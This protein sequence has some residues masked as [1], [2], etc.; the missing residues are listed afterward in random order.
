[1]T[2]AEGRR[3]WRRLR[4]WGDRIDNRAFLMDWEPVGIDLADEPIRDEIRRKAYRL[5]RWLRPPVVVGSADFTDL[6][7]AASMLR[8]RAAPFPNLN[9]LIARGLV[10][11]CYRASDGELGVTLQSVEEERNWRRTASTWRRWKRRLGG[12]LHFVS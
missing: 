2:E 3:R 12:V 8:S 1:M 5:R 4:D 11:A 7:T 9:L 10:Q 6:A